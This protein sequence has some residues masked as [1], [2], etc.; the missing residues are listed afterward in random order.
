MPTIQLHPVEHVLVFRH[1][2]PIFHDHVGAKV[3]RL[4]KWKEQK[5]W[6]QSQEESVVRTIGPTTGSHRWTR[7]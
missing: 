7:I 1:C 3:L 6:V 5:E 4:M 2:I